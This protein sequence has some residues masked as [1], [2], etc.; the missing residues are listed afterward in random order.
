M[1]VVPDPDRTPVEV[2]ISTRTLVRIVLTI[3]GLVALL[4]AF[5]AARAIVELVVISAFLALALNPIVTVLERRMNSRGGAA[6]LVVLGVLIILAL[7]IAALVTPI[8]SELRALTNRAPQLVDELRAWGPFAQLDAR[9]DFLERLRETATQYQDRLPA[10]ASNL[11]GYATAVVTGF[12]K[13]LT[14]LF[15]TLF[16]LL[17]IPRFLRTA[18]ELVR[19]GTADRSLVMFDQVNTTI[20]RW[21]GGV[22]LVATIAGLVTGISAWVVGVPFALALGLLVG[23]FGI[24]PL[25]GATI[26][27]TVVV[28]VAFTQSVTAGVI[29][30]VIAISYQFLENHVIQPVVMRKTIDVSPFIVLVSVLIGASLLGIVGAL[31]A[32]PVAGAA[33]VVLREVLTARRAR[34]AAEREL[35]AEGIVEEGPA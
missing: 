22:L 4:A 19:P 8:Y 2:T 29:M 24:I 32:V 3:F 31:L 9:Y 15:M 10:Q 7:F 33:Q 21:T 28:L 11:L 34:V 26:G 23:L 5:W 6:V 27:S 18:T 25:I 30:L 14:V 20:A 35:I 16:L 12:G 1:P 13:S 17:E